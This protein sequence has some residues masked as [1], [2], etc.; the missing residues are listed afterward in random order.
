MIDKIAYELVNHIASKVEYID[1]WAGL[2]KPM[3]KKVQNTDKVFPV[4]I[5]TPS[6][7][8]QS[9]YMALVPDSSKKSIVYVEQIGNLAVEMPNKRYKSVSGVLRLVVWYNLDLLTQGEY[10][11]TD[12]LVDEMLRNIPLR[13]ADSSFIGVKQV[14]FI[15]TGVIYGADIV[16]AYTYNEIK[17]Q[18][19]THPYGIFAVD[20]DVWYIST[21]C[22]IPIS[23]LAGCVTGVGNHETSTDYP[24][25]EP[26]P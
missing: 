15:P 22:Q 10:I 13:L 6:N 21:P 4:A 18:F 8:E 23:P 12:V 26:A 1:R 2:V 25:Q 20:L 9:D 16:S 19:N 3:R 5:N 17:T 7:C 14:H 24:A 11:S